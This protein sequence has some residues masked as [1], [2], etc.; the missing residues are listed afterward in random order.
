MPKYDPPKKIPLL[1]RGSG[2]PLN[3]WLL[4]RLEF[5]PR[6]KT[7]FERLGYIID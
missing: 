7:V 3:T 5:T 2:L 4:G 6:A 1:V